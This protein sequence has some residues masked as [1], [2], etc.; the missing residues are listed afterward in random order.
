MWKIGKVVFPHQCPVCKKYDYV[1]TGEYSYSEYKYKETVYL[2]Y[3]PQ[4]TATTKYVYVDED[5][6]VCT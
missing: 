4:D 3:T 5:P 1:S 6:Y 2:T